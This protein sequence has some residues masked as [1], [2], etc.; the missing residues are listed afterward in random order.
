MSQSSGQ[1]K[2]GGSF[3]PQEYVKGRSQ[4]RANIMALMLF[5]LVIAGVVGAFVVNHQRWRRVRVEHNQVSAAF[6]EEASK[7]KQLEE[8]E[9]Q[10]EE[11]VARAEVVTALK[12]RI[13]RSV[14]M[15]EIVR[16]I[17]D[18]LTLTELNMEGERIKP[19]APKVDPKAKAKTRTL[20]G[21]SVGKGSEEAEE[22]T[23]KVLP[24]RFKF[25]LSIDGIAMENDQV[26]DFLES[27]KESPLFQDVELP[28]IDQ[29]IIDKQ[30]YR[31]FK[32][33]LNLR[34]QAD[35]RLVDGTEEFEIGRVDF[36]IAEV[37]TDDQ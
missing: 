28:L 37:K 3:L 15:G 31:K 18:G 30:A 26:A 6:E 14:L 29:T 8:L 10:R 17:P 22:E 19:P 23:P 13:P 11:L 32:V 4:L 33:T 12:D 1:H 35:A 20:K 27:L 9:K 7:I 21:K 25:R 34:E 2:P 36:G 16:A 24:P 5:M